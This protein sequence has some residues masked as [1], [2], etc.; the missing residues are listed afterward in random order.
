MNETITFEISEE[1]YEEIM[2]H[3]DTLGISLEDFL[4]QAMQKKLK[5]Q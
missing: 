5:E 2:A 1:L 4:V 3:V